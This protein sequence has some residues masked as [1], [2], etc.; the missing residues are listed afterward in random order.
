MVT[1]QFI[2]AGHL[3]GYIKSSE[4][5]PH[6][7]WWTWCP[8]GWEWAIETFQPKTL[9]DVGC[10]EGHTLRFFLER[11][12]SAVGIDGM[13]SVREAGIV[14]PT[15]IIEHDFTLGSLEGSVDFGVDLVWSCEFVE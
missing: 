7:D 3:G 15:S 14:H 1:P 8:Q 13:A 5:F 11:G 4:N 9:I 6:G 2:N 12:V 10:G